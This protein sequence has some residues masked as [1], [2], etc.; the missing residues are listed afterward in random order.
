MTAVARLLAI[1]VD[2]LLHDSRFY[3][4]SNMQYPLK[5][6]AN[7]FC[8]CAMR[9]VT[10]TRLRLPDGSFKFGSTNFKELGR[11]GSMIMM[12]GMAPITDFVN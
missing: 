1:Q 12:A 11:L 2:L 5:D 3:T 9:K 7:A 6:R 8:V 10:R 4:L